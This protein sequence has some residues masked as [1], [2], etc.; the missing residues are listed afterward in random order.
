VIEPAPPMPWRTL[1][2]SGHAS[3][4]AVT[5]WSKLVLREEIGEMPGDL[6]GL[7]SHSLN[8]L[9]TQGCWPSQIPVPKSRRGR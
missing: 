4:A 6:S 8:R 5:R 2:R 1:A 3:C 9:Q 7:T